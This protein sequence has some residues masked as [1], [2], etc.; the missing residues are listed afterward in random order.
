[1]R[2]KKL[3]KVGDYLTT[4]CFIQ[5]FK[6]TI[7]FFFDRYFCS[8]DIYYF[9]K[10]A[11]SAIFCFLISGRRKKYQKGNLGTTNYW[12]WQITILIN[13]NNFNILVMK[14]TQINFLYGRNA[15]I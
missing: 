10:F 4:G 11:H 7:F 1:M 6:M 8:Q 14:V 5:P 13:K 2:I 12:E 15:D 3:I 9:C